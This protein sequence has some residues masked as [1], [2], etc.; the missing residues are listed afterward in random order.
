MHSFLLTFPGR[1]CDTSEV[2]QEERL[3][4]SKRSAKVQPLGVREERVCDPLG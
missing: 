2:D 3:S 4:R 1:G